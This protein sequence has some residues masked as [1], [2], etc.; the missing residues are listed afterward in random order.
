[1]Q[2]ATGKYRGFYHRYHL[3][4]TT[5]YRYKVLTWPCA[6]GSA[7]CIGGSAANETHILRGVLSSDHVRMFVSASLLPFTETGRRLG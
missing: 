4:V 6:C 5:K 3:V 1:M 7:T 2:P